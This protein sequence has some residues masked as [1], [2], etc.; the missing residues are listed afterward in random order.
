MKSKSDFWL[1]LH[2]LADDLQKEGSTD[3][4]RADGLIEVLESQSPAT[5]EA[6]IEN[7]TVVT[8]SLS[9][10]LEACKVR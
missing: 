10:L 1:S 6:Y 7:L 5:I 8:G 2:K 3:Q 9:H 4:E